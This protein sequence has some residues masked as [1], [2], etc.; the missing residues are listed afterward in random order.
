MKEGGRSFATGFRIQGG[1]LLALLLLGVFASPVWG[2]GSSLHACLYRN[3][4]PR[5]ALQFAPADTITACLIVKDLPAGR[6]TF[7]ADWYNAAGELQESSRY[8]FEQGAN[9]IDRIEARLELIKASPLRRIFSGSEATG[10]H[11]KFYGQWQV[12]FFLNGEE[13]DRKIFEIK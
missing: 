1:S 13:I 5:P 3:E 10:Y 11:I 2:R 7:H 4:D 6:Y 12:R 8:P 9:R